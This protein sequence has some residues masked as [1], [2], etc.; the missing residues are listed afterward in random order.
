VTGEL[1][2]VVDRTLAKDPAERFQ[3]AEEVSRALVQILP[4]AAGDRVKV[5]R[6]LGSLALESLVRVTLVG[7]LAAVAFVAGA[8]VVSWTV[9]SRPPRVLAAAPVPDSITAMLWRRG[10][11]ARGDTAVLA[12]A[13]DGDADSALFVVGRRRV[14]VAAP[15][16]LR[17]YARDSVAFALGVRWR[18][19]PRFSFVLMPARGR[20]DTVFRSLSP[21]AVWSLGRAVDPLLP[22]DSLPGGVRIQ[23]DQPGPVRVRVR[24]RPKPV[25]AKGR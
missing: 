1:A 23:F 18:G 9:F 7:C 2:A 25:R 24:G 19:G 8:V 17:G 10:I 4:T 6:G 15:G 5:R 16:H 13:P 20:R 11:L 14:A 22:Q 3:T 21:R 12:F